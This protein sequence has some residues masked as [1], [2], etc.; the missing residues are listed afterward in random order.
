MAA[1]EKER[2]QPELT[3]DVSAAVVHFGTIQWRDQ[4][5]DFYALLALASAEATNPR[6]YIS[7]DALA[8]VGPWRHKAPA[9]VG[10]EVAR[11]L[12]ALERRG[13]SQLVACKGRT[14]AWALDLP[15]GAVHFR[16][17]RAQVAAWVLH[18]SSP[19]ASHETWIDDLERLIVATGEL[20][21][22]QAEAVLAQVERPLTYAG[23]PALEAWSALLVGRAAYQHDDHALLVDQ[24]ERWLRRSDAIGRTVGARLRALL[25]YK[26]RHEDTTNALAAL[27]RLAA[28]LELGGD[29]GALAVVLNI[30]GILVMRTGDPRGAIAL[31]LRAAALFGIVG[32]YPSLQAALFN[33]A[34]SCRRARLHERLLPDEAVFRVVELCRTICRDFG[35]GAD[36]AQAEIA[37]ARWAFEMGDMPR[38][39]KYLALAETIVVAIESSFD[40][41][42]F[43]TLRAEIELA[44]PSGACDVTRDLNAAERLFRDVRDEQSAAEVR[45]LQKRAAGRRRR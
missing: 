12:A 30:M 10:K 38:A 7:A 9:S 18:R 4:W 26:N 40:Q 32:D 28:D 20:Q 21:R 17:G 23:E 11:H 6:R 34:N 37:A 29:V 19:I 45:L 5:L 25:A 35:V 44:D 41:A 31:H 13:L 33:L 42:L 15:A 3:I 39:R 24:Y 43:L 16:P 1:S 2:A 36:S 8:R 27:R 14:K 22:G